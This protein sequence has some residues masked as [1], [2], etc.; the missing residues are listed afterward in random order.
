MI[1][2]NDFRGDLPLKLNQWTTVVRWEFKHLTPFIRSREFLWQEVCTS[3]NVGSRW[4]CY[5]MISGYSD[6]EMQYCMIRMNNFRSNLTEKSSTA[7]LTAT[8]SSFLR[9]SDFVSVNN[10][11][12]V[13]ESCLFVF[14]TKAFIDSQ[15][16]LGVANVLVD[17]VLSL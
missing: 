13:L 16:V 11:C 12:Y 6:P 7:S 14:Y 3:R 10:S 1:R 17:A 4:F 5:L 15:A 8:L 9:T 2:M